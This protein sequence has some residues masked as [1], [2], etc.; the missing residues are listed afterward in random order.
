LQRG[1]GSNSNWSKFK[2]VRHRSIF[3]GFA[4]LALPSRS[5]AIQHERFSAEQGDSYEALAW[6]RNGDFARTQRG[7]LWRRIQPHPRRNSKT[8]RLTE[9]YL[10]PGNS[11][12]S[13]KRLSPKHCVEALHGRLRPTPNPA[14]W[15]QPMPAPNLWVREQQV[16]RTL[17]Q[18]DI[19]CKQHREFKPD[20][21]ACCFIRKFEM[22]FEKLRRR[23]AEVIR[24]LCNK[25]RSGDVVPV[26]IL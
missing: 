8:T 11:F 20:C 18:I 6:N 14:F 10:W 16:S 26:E 19:R 1:L 12:D 24:L 13:H 17:V 4:A 25:L 23:R 22:E 7:R 21:G 15:S 5:Q 2:M 3:R 9:N